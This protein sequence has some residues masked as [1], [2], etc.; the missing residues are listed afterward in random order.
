MRTARV[1]TTAALLAAGTVGVAGPAAADHFVSLSTDGGSCF[2]GGL[3]IGIGEDLRTDNVRVRYARD[4]SL[5]DF[6]CIFPTTPPP[7][8]DWLEPW[9]GKGPYVIPRVMC[10]DEAGEL[11]EDAGS[12]RITPNGRA[13]LRCRF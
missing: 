9:T 1:L 7:S 4:G 2:A 11:H 10:E 8:Q 3:G 5:V 13:T 6:T 12:F